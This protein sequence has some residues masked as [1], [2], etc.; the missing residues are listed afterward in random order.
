MYHDAIWKE[1]TMALSAAIQ[2]RLDKVVAAFK[3]DGFSVQSFPEPLAPG[4][5]VN[6][7]FKDGRIGVSARY[8]YGTKAA[9]RYKQAY[10]VEGNHWTMGWLLG[11]MAEPAIARMTTDYR[12]NVI[13]A[14]ID[15][16]IEKSGLVQDIEQLLLDIVSEWVVK[17]K[18]D[19]PVEFDEEIKGLCQ[20]CHD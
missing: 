7:C 14:F 3:A 2:A 15:P 10:Y 5:L 11:F 18:P 4:N 17:M 8:T 1:G 19:I 16:E 13:A 6:Y 9:P 12:R 20:G